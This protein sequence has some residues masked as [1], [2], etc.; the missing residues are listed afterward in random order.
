VTIGKFG[1]LSLSDAR[2]EAKRLLSAAPERKLPAITFAITREPAPRLGVIIPDIGNALNDNVWTNYRAAQTLTHFDARSQAEF[3]AYYLQ[4]SSLRQFLADE[5][6]T[7]A[8]LRVLQGE[9]G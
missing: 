8:V 4:I 6:D 9:P 3:S 5:T 2:T 1:D 7:W